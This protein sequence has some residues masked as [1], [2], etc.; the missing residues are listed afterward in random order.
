MT[1]A[2]IIL[3]LSLAGVFGSACQTPTTRSGQATATPGASSVF[4][5]V[6]HSQLREQRPGPATPWYAWR[7]DAR[8]AVSMGVQGRVYERSVT[9][10]TDRQRSFRGRVQDIYSETT[11]RTRVHETMR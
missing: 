6:H 11:H 8:P 4:D 7:H 9:I 3:M 1:R 10:T 5:T 2:A